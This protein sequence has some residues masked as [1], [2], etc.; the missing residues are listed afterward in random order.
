M[1]HLCNSLFSCRRCMELCHYF[2]Y[3]HCADVY[4]TCCSSSSGAILPSGILIVFAGNVSTSTE[5]NV[6]FLTMYSPSGRSF[7]DLMIPV[8]ID[9]YLRSRQR[10][11]RRLH[12]QPKP[13]CKAETLKNY[14]LEISFFF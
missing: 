5:Y 3:P 6:P 9:S 13:R 12:S 4:S 14:L 2:S 10:N 7:I 8:I 11:N 1:V